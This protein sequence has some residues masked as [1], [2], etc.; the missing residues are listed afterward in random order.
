MFS[1][2]FYLLCQLF[3]VIGAWFGLIDML[4]KEIDQALYNG[5]VGFGLIAT[6]CVMSFAIM[7]VGVKIRDFLL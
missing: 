6:A 7:Y 4:P 3:V 5:L 2:A 1:G